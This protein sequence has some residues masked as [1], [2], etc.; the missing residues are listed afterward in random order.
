MSPRPIAVLL[1][2]LLAVLGLA[3]PAAALAAPVQTLTWTGNNST[4]EYASAP[5]GALPGETTI[6]FENSEATGNTTGMSHT[7][8]FDTSTPGYNHDV[9]LNILA[10]PFDPQNGRHEA[11]VT[12]TPGKYR[13]FC[14]IPG[15]T[16]MVGEFVVSDGGG[17]TTAPTVTALVAGNRDSSGNYI[18]SATVSLS[19]TDAGSGVA[20]VEYQLDGGSWTTY[21]APV[22]VSAVGM[23]MLH[24]RATDVAGNTSPEGMEHFTVVEGQGDTTPPTVTASLSGDR[25]SAG[26]YLDVATVTLTATD[27]DSTV[28]SVEYQLDGGAWTAYSAPVAVTGA[29]AHMV[30]FRATD[31]AGNTS[32]EGMSS[33][34]VVK[35]DT[36]APTVSAA[37]TGTQDA[38]GNYVGKAVVTVTASDAGSGVAAV[39]YKVDGGAWAAYSAPVQVTSAGAHTVGYRAR[40]VTGNASPEGSVAFTVVA[41]GDTTAP[42]ISMGVT[43]DQDGNWDF[44]GRA[45]VTLTAVDPESG[46]ASIEYTVDGGAWTRYATPVVITALGEHTVRA[47]ATDVAGNVSA[48]APGTFTVV[49]APPPPDA[50]PVSDTRETVV[51]GEIDSQVVNIDIGNGCTLNDVIDANAEY[52]SHDRFVKHVKAVTQELVGSGV[53]S[54]GDRNRIVTAAIES[55]IGGA[56]TAGARA[57]DVRKLL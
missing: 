22:V 5:S 48:E 40:D 2:A 19:A 32:P 35:R 4:T 7:L 37:V 41:G 33:F 10:N 16:S 3:T 28:A 43:G 44:V 14:T 51:I 20:S 49:A 57:N 52:A 26:N 8:T 24:Y 46:V 17:D 39:E 50:C 29:G 12:L 45:T 55:D 27:A 18:E 13:Y 47:R 23:H 54:S 53:L 30:H 21:A 9:S 6:V 11:V 56:P 42:V 36:T 34:T 38:D 1:T 31:A 15:H 25:D